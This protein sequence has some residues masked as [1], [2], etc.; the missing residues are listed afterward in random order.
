MK[1]VEEPT[2]E[3]TICGKQK[4]RIEKKPTKNVIVPGTDYKKQVRAVRDNK[5]IKGYLRNFL[6]TDL[7]QEN[8]KL[9][10]ENKVAYYDL[11]KLKDEN[12]ILKKENCELSWKIDDLKDHISILKQDIGLRYES[13][14]EFLRERTDS[15][16]AFK[17]V[18]KDFVDKVKYK[19]AQFEQKHDLGA[20]M[21]EF[22][23]IHKQELI[24]ERNR[25]LER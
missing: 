3:K 23:K 6:N 13:A 14:K 15:L 12:R 16:K 18:F 20:K 7:A 19:T 10:N 21:N 25:G 2:G 17:N 11:S 24:K 4:T 8:K 1:K 5:K 9:K 22:E